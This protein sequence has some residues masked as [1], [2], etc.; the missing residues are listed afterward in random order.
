MKKWIP[1]NSIFGLKPIYYINEDGEAAKIIDGVIKILR[2]TE[3]RTQTRLYE[4]D[5]AGNQ[6]PLVYHRVVYYTFYP[7]ADMNMQVYHLNGDCHDNRICNLGLT[8]GHNWDG[9][10]EFDKP[11]PPL[12]TE[13]IS[14]DGIENLVVAVVGMAVD[15]ICDY[16]KLVKNEQ[17]FYHAIRNKIVKKPSS[18]MNFKAL[19][20]DRKME[21]DKAIRWILHCKDFDMYN[22]I[23]YPRE[24]YIKRA[25][26]K[27]IKQARSQKLNI[28][29]KHYNNVH[30]KVMRDKYGITKEKWNE[31][32]KEKMYE[33]SNDQILL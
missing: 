32:N 9:K 27:A 25:M 2:P 16:L 19:M 11:M 26:E 3:Y 4:R 30:R 31:K 23:N 12:T 17:F 28:I 15:D 20:N 29:R 1:I 18:I 24:D 5:E 22:F 33:E 14:D 7:D 21:H 8:T 10:S 6:V 13:N